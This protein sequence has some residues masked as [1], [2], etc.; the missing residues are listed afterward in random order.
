[1]HAVSF[2]TIHFSGIWIKIGVKIAE[3]WRRFQISEKY[4]CACCCACQFWHTIIK[5]RD[6]L[7]LVGL[8]CL[9]FGSKFLF[10]FLYKKGE[11]IQYCPLKRDKNLCVSEI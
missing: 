11:Y 2:R 3:F 10:F 4:Y 6:E 7:L 8:K 1:M 5:K 9:L